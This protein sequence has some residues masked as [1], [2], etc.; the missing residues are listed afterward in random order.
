MFLVEVTIQH[1]DELTEKMEAMRTWL[2][3]RR[4]EPATF[5]Y[6]FASPSVGCRIEFSIEAE[7]L[8]F[9]AA[10]GGHLSGATANPAERDDLP[11]YDVAFRRA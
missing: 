9:A 8:A 10:F 7:A 4:F 11:S 6:T 3:H 1:E 2:D 5:R